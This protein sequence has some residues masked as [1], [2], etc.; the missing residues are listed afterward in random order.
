MLT[1]WKTFIFGL[2][3]A[4]APVAISYFEG[5]S[6][7]DLGVPSWMVSVIGLVIIGLRAVT[8]TPMFQNLGK[9]PPA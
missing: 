5:V 4:I 7:L 2:L 6:W 8:S 1:G 3:V 9:P